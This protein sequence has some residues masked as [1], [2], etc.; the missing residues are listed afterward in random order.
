MTSYTYDPDIIT[1]P[2]GHGVATAICGEADPYG[3]W[4]WHIEYPWGDREFYGTSAEVCAEVQQTVRSRVQ[5]SQS[6]S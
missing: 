5:T 3:G 2:A 4:R 1:M 6:H